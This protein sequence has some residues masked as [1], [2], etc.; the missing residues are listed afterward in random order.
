MTSVTAAAEIAM[1]ATL[2]MNSDRSMKSTTAPWQESR[3]PEEPVDEV[4]EETAQQQTESDRPGS[5]AELA[6]D[7]EDRDEDAD[8][9][10]REDPR[11]ARSEAECCTGIAVEGESGQRADHRHRRPI[12]EKADGEELRELIDH[13]HDCRDCEQQGHHGGARSFHP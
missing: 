13:D 4:A 6:G 2:Q 12:F 10:D 11:H 1:S 9:D 5:R 3:F 8:S 7:H